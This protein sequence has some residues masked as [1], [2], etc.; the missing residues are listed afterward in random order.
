MLQIFN[1]LAQRKERFK[2][3][4]GMV[5]MFVCGPTVYDRCHIGHARTYVTFDVIAK[6]IR[7][8]GY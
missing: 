7:S 3:V 6:Y 5:R 2:P 4:N 8:K 1:T